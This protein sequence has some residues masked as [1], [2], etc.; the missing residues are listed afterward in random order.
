MRYDWY[1]YKKGKCG[2]RHTAGRPCKDTQG[3]VG[4]VTG[5]INLQAC[6]YFFVEL[7]KISVVLSHLEF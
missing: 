7:R 6:L 3:K 2:H 5:V 1:P 4:H